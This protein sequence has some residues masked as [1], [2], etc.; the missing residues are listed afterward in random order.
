MKKV[1]FVVLLLI[2]G[3]SSFAQESSTYY[4]E[5]NT[6]SKSLEVDTDSTNYFPKLAIKFFPSHMLG[7]FG[8]TVFSLEHSIAPRYALE[9]RLGAVNS[10]DNAFTNSDDDQ[11]FA[12]KS[13]FKSS[14]MFKFK[15][16]KIDFEK[17]FFGVEAFYNDYTFDRTKTVELGC[18][19]GCSFFQELNYGMTQKEYG[20][21][22][23]AGAQ[24]FL[25]SWILVEI[26][27]ALG[28][29]YFD[30]KPDREL[31]LNVVNTFTG[32]DYPD[33][34]SGFAFAIDIALKIGVIIFK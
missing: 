13:G 1:C 31:P 20:L 9:Y 3:L 14:V 33:I 4:V 2:Y 18:G 25:E 5:E 8:A 12:N 10:R 24:F 21:R 23:N 28:V 7:R 15:T 17:P 27:G 16:S 6:A 29:E 30:I 26:S 19:V 32:A 22:L 11:Y 34:D